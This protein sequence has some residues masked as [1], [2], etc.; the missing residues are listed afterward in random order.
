ME[1]EHLW[2]HSGYGRS[3]SLPLNFAVKKSSQGMWEPRRIQVGQHPL[4]DEGSLAL[5]SQYSG[6]RRLAQDGQAA[7]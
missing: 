3:L 4:A 2:R 5:W 1:E 6:L 7:E